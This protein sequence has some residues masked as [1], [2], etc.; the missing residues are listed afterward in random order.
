M[1]KKSIPYRLLRA[2]IVLALSFALTAGIL[3]G[4]SNAPSS[5][6]AAPN[7]SGPANP[8]TSESSGQTPSDDM[9]AKVAAW[10]PD[11]KTITIR[12]S[13]AAGGTADLK[14][15]MVAKYIQDATGTSSVVQNITGANGFVMATDLAGYDPSPCELMVGTEALFAVAP[16]F[17][18]DINISL[19]DYEILFG[20]PSSSP[21]TLAVPATL[22]VKTWE[23][24]VSYAADNRVIMA[25]SAPGGMTHI[26][27]T[28]LMGSAGITFDSV[29]DSAANKNIL[30][31]LSGDANCV[32][33]NTSALHDYV[34]SGQMI[35]LLQFNKTT[36]DDVNW[37]LDPIPSV[38][39]AGYADIAVEPCTILCCRK[40]ADPV[41][42]EAMRRM[43]LEYLSSEQGIEDMASLGLTSAEITAEEAYQRL[44]AEIDTF[45]MIKDKFY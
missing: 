30:V 6:S 22:G 3:S 23:E 19:D 8:N 42:V 21:S 2:A 18:A 13:N 9:D 17:N 32:I 38:A 20:S 31:C 34:E 12:V 28:A 14:Y 5:G 4:C 35:P 43:V 39:E 40:G 33:A 16:L 45:K 36:F 37:G 41:G 24:F 11:L 7:T 26:Q 10:K 15:R 44:T 29:T 25:S 1:M 27:G